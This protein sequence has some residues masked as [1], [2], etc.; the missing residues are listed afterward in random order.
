VPEETEQS[1]INMAVLLNDMDGGRFRDESTREFSAMLKFL[2]D[3]AA[4][5]SRKAKGRLTLKFNVTV[6]KD[7][8]VRLDPDIEV[9]QPKPLRGAD[10]YFVTKTGGLSRHNLKQQELFAQRRLREVPHDP[11][12]GEVREPDS[13]AAQGES[14]K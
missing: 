11:V 9:K 7:G 4:D 13:A 10:S 1:I 5:N 12:T 14:K 3:Y 2:R 8:L 6:E